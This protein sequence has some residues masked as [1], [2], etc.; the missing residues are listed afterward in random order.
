MFPIIPRLNVFFSKF[1][2]SFGKGSSRHLLCLYWENFGAC[3]QTCNSLVSLVG[4]QL[5]HILIASQFLLLRFKSCIIPI[6]ICGFYGF[7]GILVFQYNV[8]ISY[9]HY[10]LL[11]QTKRKKFKHRSWIEVEK[12]LFNIAGFMNSK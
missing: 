4:K 12:N 6:F 7:I 5:S 11:N 1:W 10:Y 3:W 9:N 8:V 2:P